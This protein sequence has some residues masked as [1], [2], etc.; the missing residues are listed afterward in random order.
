MVGTEWWGFTPYYTRTCVRK[1]GLRL[2]RL[3]LRLRVVEDQFFKASSSLSA[4]FSA[5]PFSSSNKV[6]NLLPM[7]APAA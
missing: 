6:T 5:F 7:M 3:R 2:L 1:K 4:A